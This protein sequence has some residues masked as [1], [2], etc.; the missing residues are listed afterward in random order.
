MSGTELTALLLLIPAS[1]LLPE[2]WAV[3]MRQSWRKCAR[4]CQHPA[5]MTCLFALLAF[6]GN[7]AFSLLVRLP[8]PYVVDEFSYLFG[9]ETLMAGRLT[10]T[11]PPFHRHFSFIH[12]I[13]TPTWQMKYPPGQSLLLAF[14]SLF[15]HPIVG[16]W[17]G[18][19]LAIG[20]LCWMLQAVLPCRWAFVGT[21]LGLLNWWI[22]MRHGQSYMGT[23]LAMIGGVTTLG[24][25]VRL[26]RAPRPIYG[27]LLG[28]GLFLMAISRPYEGLI[29]SLPA[30][31]LV[32]RQLCIT[33]ARDR[34]ALL[35]AGLLPC[36]LILLI[37][38]AWLGYY[39]KQVTGSAFV[40]PYQ[41]WIQQK[42]R[43][44]LGA[45]VSSVG[46]M[47]S[48]ERHPDYNLSQRIQ[49]VL[50]HSVSRIKP[51]LL[52]CFPVN[53]AISLAFLPVVR[54]RP[55]FRFFVTTTVITWTAIF[56][57][58]P[59][60]IAPEYTGPLLGPNILLMTLGI[61]GM[62]TLKL[63]SFRIGGRL[64]VL[65]M[66]G[67]VLTFVGHCLRTE[68]AKPFPEPVQQRLQIA[69]LLQKA[70]GK[71]LVFVLPPQNPDYTFSWLSNHPDLADAEIIWALSLG[72][73]AD[74]L[75]RSHYR[76]RRGWSLS[77]EE[78]QPCLRE[79]DDTE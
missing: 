68:K 8:E 76:E 13:E 12:N 55:W 75:L 52:I 63:G 30:A 41:V 58:Q 4:F 18:M 40:M 35:I 20:G 70:S 46:R 5:L 39:H 71:D 56:L 72:S 66:A 17:A 29:M 61:R 10:N 23:S 3:I 14:G 44:T 47:I 59:M 28:L 77:W 62:S 53:L 45:L 32:L 16:A 11:T 67:T 37:S 48:D 57:E 6:A 74:Q 50:E 69:A 2:R 1:L 24:A 51:S 15:G 26:L 78:N 9:S 60:W 21:L 31:L 34:R 7:M 19:A 79:L 49:F 36:F 33:Q 22:N 65:F 42:S 54:R 38:F 27:A 43:Q 64:P 25:L 73:T